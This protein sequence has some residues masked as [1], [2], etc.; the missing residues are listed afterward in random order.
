MHG[1]LRFA[2]T[3]FNSPQLITEEAATPITSYLQS[4]L[5]NPEFV[6]VKDNK[7]KTQRSVGMVGNVGVVEISGALT[8]KPVQMMCSD[9]ENAS[10]Q[11]IVEQVEQLAERGVKS[12]VFEYASP[13]GQATH[14]FESVD[15][16]REI[17]DSNNIKSV[18][19]VD[20]MAASAALAWAVM[21]DE[22][23]VNPSASMGSI[24]CMVAL[25]DLSE[26]KKQL[27]VKEVFI[28]SAPG[29]VPFDE[30]GKFTQAFLDRVQAD[31]TALGLQ[32]AE[33]VSKYTGIAT[34][35]V[36]DMNASMFDANKSV[37]VGL[38]NKVMTHKEFSEYISQNYN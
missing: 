23:I 1:I 5:E 13:G 7:T 27:G 34:E 6:V 33:H 30:E 3:V 24:G 22:V 20:E 38:A 16:V 18:A 37:E 26:R 21:A 31:V 8:Y 17:L 36:L 10:Y 19:Y 29:K 2:G 4:R 15:A 32:F 14:C 9:E 11:S 12:I 35:T 28:T 25:L